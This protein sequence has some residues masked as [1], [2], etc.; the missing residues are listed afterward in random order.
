M[1]IDAPTKINVHTYTKGNHFHA[2]YVQDV[3]SVCAACEM[4][5]HEELLN[6]ISNVM[7]S[8]QNQKDALDVNKDELIVPSTLK[9]F[10]AGKLNFLNA[11]SSIGASALHE[12]CRENAIECVAILIK[13]GA[14]INKRCNRGRTPLHVACYK[15]NSE[16]ARMLLN[17]KSCDPSILDNSGASVLHLAVI[18]KSFPCV[19][20]LML[21]NVP[22]LFDNNGKTPL[23]IARSENI[24]DLLNPIATPSINKILNYDKIYTTL[25]HD[26]RDNILRVTSGMKH[27]YHRGCHFNFITAVK[28]RF[29]VLEDGRWYAIDNE[30]DLIGTTIE[31]LRLDWKFEN[32]K[33][34]SY[35]PHIE[36]W[37][38]HLNEHRLYGVLTKD[39]VFFRPGWYDYM[40]FILFRHFALQNRLQ[41]GKIK[42]NGKMQDLIL[43]NT[44]H[45]KNMIFLTT[46]HDEVDE[47]EAANKSN[48]HTKKAH[49]FQLILSFVGNMMRYE[50]ESKA[51][52]L[53][54]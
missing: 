50:K 48:K 10:D 52:E 1:Q 22:Q 26:V 20:L 13:Y 9:K 23:Q 15:G 7:S 16:I 5:D 35:D 36:T 21:A 43:G 17:E 49:I 19:L 32:C 40:F 29:Q 31:L 27:I 8:K 30:E 4:N 2:P 18:G 24:R 33:V 6:I 42:V 51:E 3:E 39:N 41:L 46:L 34:V 11:T 12:A 45:E 53:N 25:D 14:D 54:L 47:K 44:R 38:I 28:R 37:G